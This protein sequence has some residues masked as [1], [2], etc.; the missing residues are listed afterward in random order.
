MFKV[1]QKRS[2]GGC[3]TCKRRKKKCDER[4]PFCR[5]CELGNFHCQGYSP[6]YASHNGE[7]PSTTEAPADLTY[8][9]SRTPA[10]HLGVECSS[11][12]S[13]DPLD[14]PLNYQNEV[15]RS[16][17]TPAL[18]QEVRN[19]L[20]S[21]PSGVVLDPVILED[22]TSLIVSQYMKLSQQ[23]MFKLP[24]G[25]VAPGLLW[26][27]DNSEIT[28]WSMYL[29]AR[30]LN[31]V[32]SGNDAQKY[33]EWIFRLYQQILEF[34]PPTELGPNLE[35]RLGGLHDLVHLVFMVCGTT[36]GYSLFK[37]SAPAFLQLAVLYPNI[38]SDDS[39][40]SIPEAIQSPRYEITQFIICD[41]IVSLT[42]GTP[43]LLNYNTTPSWA[44]EAPSHYQLTYGFP[45]GILLLF[46]KVNARRTLRLTGEVGQSQEDWQ[47][48]VE[49]LNHWN[50]TPDFTDGPNNNIARFAVQEVWRQAA[51]IYLYMGMEEVNSA[52]LR[53]E[54][55][56][57][58]V[59]Q[60]AS[61]FQTDSP[62]ELH[63]MIPYLIAGAVARQEKHRAV[64]RGKLTSEMVR[65]GHM[66]A[67]RGSDFIAVLDHLW[68]GAGSE[69]RPIMWE[70]YVQSRCMV[71]PIEW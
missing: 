71:L 63:L 5:R 25:S 38:W 24:S 19:F 45:V 46:A 11:L 31:D 33:S 49:H 10:M 56:V 30:V 14:L 4:K 42:L 1:I 65:K 59:V 15:E 57:R 16:P 41:N 62:L 52:D 12:E 32:W 68:H 8:W 54:N 44:D 26:R 20:A 2:L 67:L 61:I 40:I 22:A 23:I 58:Q 3:L 60:L 70:D 29:S 50:P 17:P 39:T 21:I 36:V 34:S 6:A 53:I 18:F 13:L 51:I 9:D 69:G 27:I 47:D 66:L 37:D 48:L 28:R 43:P 35:G 7:S 64:L 55:A